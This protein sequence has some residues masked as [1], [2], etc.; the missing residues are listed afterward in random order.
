MH[1]QSF[2]IDTLAFSFFNVYGPLQRAGHVYAAVIPCSWTRCCA[3]SRCR[4][5]ATVR[6]SR[7]FTYV[8]TVCRVLLDAVERRVTDP[9]PVNLAFGTN[10]TLLELIQRIESASG[11]TAEVVHRDPR[12]GDV[13][14]SQADNSVL[15]SL[16]PDVEP[17]T[18]EQ[19]LADTLE[20]FKETS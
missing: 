7:D 16:F 19:G 4:S 17:V 1:Q 18:L 11:L 5:T 2:G 12:P 20:W 10:T 6:N 8:G 14:H 3:A 15:R 13:K 9:E